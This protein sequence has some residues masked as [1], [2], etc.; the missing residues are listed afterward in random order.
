MDHRTK[1]SEALDVGDY[2]SFQRSS[3]NLLDKVKTGY[4][5]GFVVFGAPIFLYLLFIVL[6]FITVIVSG[7]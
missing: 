1:A 7:G 2:I 3:R 5:L 4:C 6:L